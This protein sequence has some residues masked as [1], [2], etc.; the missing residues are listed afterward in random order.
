VRALDFG[1]RTVASRSRVLRQACLH[2]SPSYCASVALTG[3]HARAVWRSI[4]AASFSRARA[5]A[6]SISGPHEHPCSCRSLGRPSVRSRTSLTARKAT[7]SSSE[8]IKRL[9]LAVGGRFARAGLHVP[10]REA[11]RVPGQEVTPNGTRHA[12]SRVRVRPSKQRKYPT[13]DLSHGGRCRLSQEGT[14]P[15]CRPRRL[16]G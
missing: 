3:V 5:A 13:P 14:K 2:A 4:S 7:R 16:R 8:P 10:H 6:A 1:P 15:L 12:E 9:V 11:T